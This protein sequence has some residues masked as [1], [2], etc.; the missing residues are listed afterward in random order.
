MPLH[1]RKPLNA[2][3]LRLPASIR[4]RPRVISINSNVA[5]WPQGG[6]STPTHCLSTP[7]PGFHFQRR[8]M[9]KAATTL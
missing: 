6:R 5:A 3:W 8:Q 4:R 1:G 2:A 7:I 9:M